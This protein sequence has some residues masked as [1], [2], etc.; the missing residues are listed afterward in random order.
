MKQFTMSQYASLTDLLSAR[1]A[2]FEALADAACNR[3]RE[4]G[5]IRLDGD[6]GEYYWEATG[7]YLV[8]D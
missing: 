4:I 5:E 7:E 1:S 6:G 3:L 2:Y 8:K